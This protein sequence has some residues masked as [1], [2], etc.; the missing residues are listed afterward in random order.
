MTRDDGTYRFERLPPGRFV[1]AIDL[2]AADRSL[3][4]AAHASRLTGALA[5]GERRS[6]ETIAL[7]PEVPIA[8]L[9]GIVRGADGAAAAHVRVFLRGGD[10]EGHVVGE[11]AVTDALG[12]FAIAVIE[13]VS[14]EVFAVREE[15]GAV[16]R[17][18]FSAPVAFTASAATPPVVVTLRRSF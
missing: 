9:E 15:R 17:T 16:R 14:Y 11:P 1:V 13:G 7:P 5:A 6:V 18:E 3:A 8:R 10:E 2:P 12:R 4:A